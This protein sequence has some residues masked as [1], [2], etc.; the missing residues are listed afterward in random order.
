[1]AYRE[2]GDWPKALEYVRKAQ[3]LLPGDP[4]TESW[5]KT[6]K[7]VLLQPQQN[8]TLTT[9]EFGTRIRYDSWIAGEHIAD[10]ADGHPN[11]GNHQENHEN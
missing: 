5:A 2:L 6:F 7:Q 10:H 4:E 3:K 1:M 11:P 9:L 8:Y